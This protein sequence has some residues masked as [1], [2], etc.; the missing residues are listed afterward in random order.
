LPY[1][2]FTVVLLP[3][4]ASREHLHRALLLLEEL[5]DQLRAPTFSPA[6]DDQ[7][8]LLTAAR[9]R[10]LLAGAALESSPDP[11]RSWVRL[12]GV[13]RKRAWLGMV[14]LALAAL[15]A[16]AA[17]FVVRSVWRYMGVVLRLVHTLRAIWP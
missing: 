8:G 4:E 2:L 13:A 7:V 3:V 10:L 14:L 11:P 6:R 15:V 9:R 1:V 5:G 16:R 17:G 12:G